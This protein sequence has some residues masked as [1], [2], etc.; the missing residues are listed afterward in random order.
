ML[1]YYDYTGDTA[2]VRTRLV[3]VATEVLR[4]FDTNGGVLEAGIIDSEGR[5]IPFSSRMLKH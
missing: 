4:Y 3:P 5:R 2:F 1:D